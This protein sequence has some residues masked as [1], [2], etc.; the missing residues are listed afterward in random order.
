MLAYIAQDDLTFADLLE[1]S[2]PFLFHMSTKIQPH[3]PSFLT[4]KI[5]KLISA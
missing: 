3:W 4:L 5:A 2:C 1:V